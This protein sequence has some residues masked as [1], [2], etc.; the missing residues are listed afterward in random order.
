MMSS[1]S[2]VRLTAHP[3]VANRV[4]VLLID[5]DPLL[6]ESLSTQRSHWQGIEFVGCRTGF[7]VDSMEFLERVSPKVVLTDVLSFSAGYHQLVN[8]LN[9]R[10][11]RSRLGVFAD[12]LSDSQIEL[13]VT[14]GVRG[15]FSRSEPVSMLA[16]GLQ[17]LA[18]G[19]YYVAA[20]LQHRVARDPRS[21]RFVVHRRSH[22]ADLSNRQ[23]EVLVQL[24]EGRRVKEI[25]TSMRLSEK[26]I[27]SHK[28]R[29][30]NRLGI[31]DRVALCRWAIREGLIIA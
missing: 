7:D 19:H 26:A 31:H 28:Y 5:R 17:D 9:I 24:A 3:Q 14:G 4:T 8:H 13:A 1:I 18:G 23:L 15:L 6:I 12:T 21:G 16:A 11:G 2:S 27:E 10:L 22:L 20:S 29:L 25:A 30:M